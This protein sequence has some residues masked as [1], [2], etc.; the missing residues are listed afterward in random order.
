MSIL[1][2]GVVCTELDI[3]V[4]YCDFISVLSGF[5]LL[6]NICLKSTKLII[7]L[8]KLVFYHIL[9]H[10]HTPVCQVK[11]VVDIYRHVC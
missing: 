4:F 9:E 1:Y 10:L 7:L 11:M 8:V 3:Y 2:K 6:L 5:Y